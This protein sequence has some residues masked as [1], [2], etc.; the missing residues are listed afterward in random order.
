MD[1]SVHRVDGEKSAKAIIDGVT[2]RKQA[3][4]AEQHVVGE[5]EH[6]HDA[7]EAHHRERAAR[8]ED[9]RQDREREGERDPWRRKPCR[10]REAHRPQTRARRHVDDIR[11]YIAQFWLNVRAFP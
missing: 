1:H 10:S 4:F 6:D 7:H 8:R 9:R 2:K 3:G 11:R 5:R